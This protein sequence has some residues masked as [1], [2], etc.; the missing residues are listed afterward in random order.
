VNAVD[1]VLLKVRELTDCAASSERV[2][3]SLAVLTLKMASSAEPG[4]TLGFG[5][6]ASEAVDQFAEGTQLPLAPCQ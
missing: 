3:G 2:V 1:P 5:V 6:F 4:A